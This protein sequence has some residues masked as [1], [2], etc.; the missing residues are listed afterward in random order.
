M[1]FRVGSLRSHSHR[2][3]PVAKGMKI[4]SQALGI[5]AWQGKVTIAKNSEP[6][7]RMFFHLKGFVSNTDLAQPPPNFRRSP[8]GFCTRCASFK[9]ALTVTSSRT[10]PRPRR[11]SGTRLKRPADRSANDFAAAITRSEM[12]SRRFW[13]ASWPTPSSV[14]CGCA[15]AFTRWQPVRWYIDTFSMEPRRIRNISRA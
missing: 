13:P 8:I 6:N 7:L 3:S 1:I 4:A 14:R 12:A 11:R 10:A 2:R 5:T 15:A 9:P